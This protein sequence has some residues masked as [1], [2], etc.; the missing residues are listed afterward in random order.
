[1]GVIRSATPLP[2]RRSQV[3]R[4]ACFGI[5]VEADLLRVRPSSSL[6]GSTLLIALR[7]DTEFFTLISFFVLFCEKTER[8][9]VHRE[10]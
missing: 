8:N 9:Q 4:K 1:V 7:R 3:K 2:A 10:K 5:E 6:S